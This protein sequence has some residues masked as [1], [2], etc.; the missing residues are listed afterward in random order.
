MALAMQSDLRQTF[1]ALGDSSR[2]QIAQLLLNQ[3][4]LCVSELAT[5]IGITAAGVSQHMRVLV[6]AGIVHPKRVGQKMCYQL[7]DEVTRVRR[8]LQLINEEQL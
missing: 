7:N 5:K 2:Y 4:E 1:G 8:V 3:P 6:Q